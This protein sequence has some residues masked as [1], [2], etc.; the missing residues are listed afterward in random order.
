VVEIRR[1]K[2]DQRERRDKEEWALVESRVPLR[3]GKA[4][5]LIPFVFHGPRHA[6][7]EVD[8]H[9]SF[10]QVVLFRWGRCLGFECVGAALGFGKLVLGEE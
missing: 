9:S 8:S 2:K 3:L 10:V 5:P 7:P 6:L 1:P 4:L